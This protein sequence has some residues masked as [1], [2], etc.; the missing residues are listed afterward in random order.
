MFYSLGSVPCGDSCLFGWVV[1]FWAVNSK[2]EVVNCPYLVLS[3]FII[4]FFFASLTWLLGPC[5]TPIICKGLKFSNSK[6]I[7]F[8]LVAGYSTSPCLSRHLDMTFTGRRETLGRFSL[9]LSGLVV[10]QCELLS[11]HH[12]YFLVHVWVPALGTKSFF[13]SISVKLRNS[14]SF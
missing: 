1:F 3:H 8:G 12:H 14:L 11:L 7:A 5:I 10:L 4:I 9:I 6:F 2:N 13:L